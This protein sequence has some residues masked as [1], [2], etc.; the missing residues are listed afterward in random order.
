VKPIHFVL[1]ATAVEAYARGSE[2]VGEP[3]TK[4]IENGAAFT[5]PLTVLAS[6][7]ARSTQRG[8]TC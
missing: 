7:G 2:H 1:D 8:L 5:A 4:I 6:A 3:L